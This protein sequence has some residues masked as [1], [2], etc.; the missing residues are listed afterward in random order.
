[1]SSF[2]HSTAAAAAV[3]AHFR[4]VSGAVPLGQM[5]VQR[6]SQA[7]FLGNV[8]CQRNYAFHSCANCYLLVFGV[9]EHERPLLDT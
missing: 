5:Q 4:A 6:I 8:R 2:L 7:I 3:P 1:M 9:I